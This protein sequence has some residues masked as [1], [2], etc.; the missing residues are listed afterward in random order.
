MTSNNVAVK[1]HSDSQEDSKPKLNTALV[2]RLSTQW[3]LPS[4]WENYFSV[5][6]NGQVIQCPTCDWR[7]EPEVPHHR[8]WKVMSNHIAVYHGPKAKAKLPPRLQRVK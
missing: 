5:R 8:R 4:G 3:N 7:P 2:R 6:G 1:P